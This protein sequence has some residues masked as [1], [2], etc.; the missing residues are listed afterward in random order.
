MSGVT[1]NVF[2]T[3]DAVAS[4]KVSG[5]TSV[6]HATVY[7]SGRI[8]P[9]VFFSGGRGASYFT[10]EKLLRFWVTTPGI[11]KKYV[12]YFLSKF[13]IGQVFPNQTHSLNIHGY[14]IK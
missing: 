11:R 5:S 13:L 6:V 4:W 10:A 7:L 14:F 1:A 12:F 2:S 8:I 3:R 9:V